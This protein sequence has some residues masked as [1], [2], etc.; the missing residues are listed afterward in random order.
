MICVMRLRPAGLRHVPAVS[1]LGRAPATWA[2]PRA[3][4]A[5]IAHGTRRWPARRFARPMTNVIGSSGTA[6]ARAGL[7]HL[8]LVTTGTGQDPCAAAESWHGLS[9]QARRRTP[10]LRRQA[11]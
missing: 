5:G 11:R 4:G 6:H 7:V 8:E 9:K 3:C 10:Q 2:D 1:G